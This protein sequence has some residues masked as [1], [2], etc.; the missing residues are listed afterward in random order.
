MKSNL[1][2]I[3]ALALLLEAGTT[4]ALAAKAMTPDEGNPVPETAQPDASVA[5][6]SLTGLPLPRFA[7]LRSG[8]VNM[9]TGPGTRYPI[10]WVYNRKQLPVE[11]TAEYDIWR[12]VRDPDG[13]EGW[14]HKNELS[15]KR[16]AL[17]IG[18]VP[19][20]REL[21]DSPGDETP[22]VAHLEV[23]A[24]GQLLSCQD[25]WCRLKFAGVKGY[26]RKT[27]FWGAY[28]NENFN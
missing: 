5:V 8:E 28:P 17:V 26:L 16:G 19:G 4:A 25:D 10:E 20:V 3:L 24:V 9:R 7:S 18:T 23:G 12:R 22:S 14:V 13:N 27:N 6:K 2:A 1:A 11:I 21:R 15:G